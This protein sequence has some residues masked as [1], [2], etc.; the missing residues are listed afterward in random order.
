[1]TSHIQCRVS[2]PS[3]PLILSQVCCSSV[4]PLGHLLGTVETMHCS[5]AQ[6]HSMRSAFQNKQRLL[7][8][9]R[10][11]LT[12]CKETLTVARQSMTC[13][14]RYLNL[15]G[16]APSPPGAPKNRKLQ[17]KSAGALNV[18]KQVRSEALQDHRS[19]RT[20]CML[21]PVNLADGMCHRLRCLVAETGRV[22]RLHEGLQQC[23]GSLSEQPMVSRGRRL[24]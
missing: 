21:Q 15:L 5:A 3:I 1:M 22:S 4:A 17:R 18:H 8:Q 20:V 23:W 14:T 24:P 13:M 12:M 9:L 7:V 10:F 11:G 19:H 16:R 6:V 2:G